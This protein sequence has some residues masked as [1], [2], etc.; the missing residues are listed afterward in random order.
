MKKAIKIGR[1]WQVFS[2][3]IV[4]FTL[5]E[6]L[7]V[8]AI[9]AIL[10]SMLLPALN[11]ARE[12]ARSISC[13]SNLKQLGTGTLMYTDDNNG[14]LFPYKISNGKRWYDS[15]DGALS[16]YL[17]M[18][19][20][21]PHT[22]IGT[23]GGNSAGYENERSPLS[24]PS[25]PLKTGVITRSYGYSWNIAYPSASYPNTQKL[26]SFAKP[27]KSVIF[28]DISSTAAPYVNGYKWSDTDS[29]GYYG[30]YYRHGGSGAFDGKANIT[31]A[32]G[33]VAPKAYNEVPTYS[34]DG[35]WTTIIVRTVWWNPG[36]HK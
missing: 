26:S 20:K 21:V 27:T 8:I 35:G 11:M 22:Y 18:L 7:V 16:L 30:V 12:K 2:K 33:H 13:V 1:N 15:A 24:C 23:V 28:S 17:P 19:R 32:D 9:I 10:A 36:Y 34:R 31:F 4:R 3:K 25:V 29:H 5:I 6:L 14:T